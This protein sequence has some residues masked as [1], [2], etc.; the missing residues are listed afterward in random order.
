MKQTLAAVFVVGLLAVTSA[1]RV[2]ADWLRFR[3]PD[4]QGISPESKVPVQWSESENLRWKA[5]LP[6]PGSSSP[7]VLQG[8]VY[9]TC[10]SGYGVDA[11]GPGNMEDLQRHLLCVD[12]QSGEVIWSKAVPAEMPEDPFR[13]FITE[14]GYASST[15]VTDGQR[16]YVFFGKTG[17]LAFDLD[18]QQLWQ[19]DVGKESSNR[20]WGSAASPILYKDMVIVNASEESQSIRALDKATGDE[21]WK[22]EG[23]SLDLAYGTPA[24]VTVDNGQQQLVIGLPGEIWSLNPDT[25]KL[26]SYLETSLSGNISPSVV[27]GDG[28][29]FLFG[30]YPRMGSQAWRPGGKGNVSDS[31]MVW[32][33]RTSSYVATP[34]FHEGHLYWVDD[35]G[36]AHCMEAKTGGEVYRERMPDVSGGGKPFYAS[37]IL[38][39]GNLYVVSRRSGTYVLTATPEFQIVAHNRLASDD[40]DFNGTVAISDGAIFLRSNR[41]LYCVA[42]D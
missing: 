30:G 15:P 19:V 39:N 26:Q 41:F 10:Y 3:G 32:T 28:L 37:P 34:V 5:E 35:R 6:G 20:Q 36:I 31:H 4:G 22:A 2:D 9:V 17:V 21:R 12:G 25:G 40:S 33:S 11:D 38:A 18:G 7:I 23:S 13:G 24:L 27:Q 1:T 14:H 42:A 29:L 16:I 8:R